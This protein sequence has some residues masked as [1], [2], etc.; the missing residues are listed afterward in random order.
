MMFGSFRLFMCNKA[1]MMTSNVAMN[2]G[3]ELE[4]G[5]LVAKQARAKSEE[6]ARICFHCPYPSSL[7]RSLPPSHLL[8]L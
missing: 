6:T 2:Q 3:A 7:R 5:L 1:L 4:C 8:S